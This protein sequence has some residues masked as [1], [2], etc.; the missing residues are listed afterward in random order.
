[1]CGRFALAA[2]P[3]QL[4]ELLA[5]SEPPAL[6][7]R[8]NIAPT[9]AVAAVRA[10]EGGREL[11]MLRWGLI[12][13]WAKDPAIGAKM[14]NARAETA[15]EK[16]AFRAAFR[17]RRCLIP[18]DG[19]YEWRRV[20]DGKQPYFIGMA[21][22]GPF[23]FAGLWESWQGPDGAAVETC[24]ILTTDANELLRPLHERMPVIL[25]PADHRLWLD[26]AVTDATPEL[27][28]LL[29]PYPVAAMTA[30][31]VSRRVNSPR[32]DDSGCRE[33]AA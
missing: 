5:L 16:P 15:H 20:E 13:G 14:I 1:M 2:D 28:G 4:A 6:P 25:P 12:P 27:R 7:P 30:Y 3:A 9:Q 26:P 8:H 22:G 21:D 19:F 29:R 31:P 11:A 17:R 10:G 32:N 24:T 23:A 33:P 18:A